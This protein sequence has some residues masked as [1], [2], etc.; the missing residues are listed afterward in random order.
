MSNAALLD[1]Q[2]EESNAILNFDSDLPDEPLKPSDASMCVRAMIL[3]CIM[4]LTFGSTSRATLRHVYGRPPLT[5]H[6][7][8]LCI[9]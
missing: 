8:T 3:M 6:D 9:R 1:L 2:T 4:S 5:A 7:I